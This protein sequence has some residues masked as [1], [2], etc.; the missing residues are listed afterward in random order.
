MRDAGFY[1][2]DSWR[3]RP[4]LTINYGLRY[5]LQMPFSAANSLYSTTNLEGVWGPSGYADGCD[6][7]EPTIDKCNLFRPGFLPGSTAT[8]V[9]TQLASG[10]SAYDTDMNNWAPSFGVNWTP[11]AEKGFLRTLMGQPGDFAIRGGWSRSFN[12]EGM[13]NFTGVYN[14]NP[15]VS[16]TANRTEALGN[17]G[18]LPLLLRNPVTPASF[19]ESPVYPL[20][21]VI[22][23]DVNTFAPNLQVPYADSYTIGL[24]RGLTRNMAIEVRYVG[25]RSRE[26]LATYNL[27][28]INIHENGFLNEFKLAQQNLQAHIASGCVGAACS[29]AYRGPG[30]GTSPL[31]IYLAYFT[32]LTTAG[33]VASYTGTNWTNSTFVN[34]LALRNPNPFGAAN[35]LDDDPARRAFALTAGLPSN[36]L[37]A[38]PN[39]LGGANITGNGGFSDYNSVQ[40]ELR[41]RLANGFQF[42]ANY[43]YG[44]ATS[45]QRY[46]FRVPRESLRQ[47]GGE[48]EVTHA[49]KLNWVFELPIGRGKRWGSDFGPVMDRIAG[50]WQVHG[51]MRIQSGRL[52]DFGNVRMVGFD[53]KELWNDLYKLRINETQRVFMLPQAM[54][55]E[56]IK[57]FSI[58]ATSANGYGA[59]G[60]P[61]GKYFAPANGADCIETISNDYG[62]C[63]VRSLIMRGPMFREVDISIMKQVPIAGR[64]RAEFRIEMLNAF[65]FV[66]YVPVTGIGSNPTN[67]EISGVTGATTARVIQLVTR[68]S[69]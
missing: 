49:V 30:T 31:P 65:N 2:Q 24:Q 66:N 9:F 44:V 53:A 26:L 43:V 64:T 42:Q 46:S 61:S 36:F 47:S 16:I 60:A 6:A 12:R 29:F 59:L 17:L 22:T 37:L 5:E 55:D 39:Y 52:V 21:D 62:E 19:P 57:A 38:N 7:S 69:W 41:R 51:N 10:T 35:S 58:S 48:G 11:S 54:I 56:T 4:N 1:V 28:E 33:S 68:I 15:G 14:A 3:A 23:G 34:P 45:S 32:G 8:T 50:G 27:N 40:M 63:G 18:A 20:S 25:T 67:Y 13:T